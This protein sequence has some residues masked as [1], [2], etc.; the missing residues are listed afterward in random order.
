MSTAASR[1]RSQSILRA[2]VLIVVGGLFCI[3]L[4]SLFR[5]STAPRANAGTWD[6]WTALASDPRLLAAIRVS[7]ELAALTVVL[8][9]VLL[10]PTMVWV[11]L[12]VPRASR[13]VEFLCLLPL[14]IPAIVIVVGIAPVMAWVWYLVTGSA[15]SLTFPF[16]ILVLP[17]CYRALDAGLSVLDVNTLAEAARSLG[18]SWFTVIVRIIVPNIKSAVLNAAFLAVAVVLGEY[19]FASLL[20]YDTL[21]VV[22]AQ[23]GLRNAR[24]STA[25]S[26]ATLAFGFLL[27]FV[28]SFVGSRRK[29]RR[30]S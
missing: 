23:Y 26:L 13:L 24:V 27:L 18:A 7:V 4:Y 16:V 5:F 28:L 30:A 17:Y 22:I 6:A 8:M 10:L 15:L 1:R 2:V 12:R 19:T 29:G 11:R 3:P 21:Q 25:L 20:H 14:T 9:L